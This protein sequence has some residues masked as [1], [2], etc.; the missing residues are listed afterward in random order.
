MDN[1][2]KREY[3]RRMYDCGYRY[4]VFI[5]DPE[6]GL[7]DFCFKMADKVGPFLREEYPRAKVAS[8]WNLEKIFAR[9]E[10]K[11]V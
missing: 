11:E 6:A 8:V 3:L 1:I 5:E 7:L 4:C 2:P 10:A 9:K